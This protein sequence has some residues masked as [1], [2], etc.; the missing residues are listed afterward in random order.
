MEG[1]LLLLSPK[2]AREARLRF[3]VLEDGQLRCLERPGGPALESVALTRHQVRVQPLMDD[4]ADAHGQCPNRFALHAV[5]LRR[6]DARNAFVVPQGARVRSLVLAA[7]SAK[8][9]ARWVNAL[10]NWRR[11]SFEEPAGAAAHGREQLAL[12]DAISR[13]DMRLVTTES[14][15]KAKTVVCNPAEEQ[16]QERKKQQQESVLRRPARATA[17]IASWLPV[18]RLSSFRLSASG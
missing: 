1:Y 17:R 15:S 12:L 9:M 14:K 4:D 8:A 18:P 6:S 3:C 2:R 16:A 10:H 5:E 13:F 11:H 7:A